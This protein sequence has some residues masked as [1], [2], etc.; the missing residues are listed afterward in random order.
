MCLCTIPLYGIEKSEEKLSIDELKMPIAE[1]LFRLIQLE[2]ITKPEEI[3]ISTL[4]DVIAQE[5]KTVINSPKDDANDDSI[6][7][8][9]KLK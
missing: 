6:N 5:C 2:M 4:A 1:G 3:K 8:L 9:I 7:P